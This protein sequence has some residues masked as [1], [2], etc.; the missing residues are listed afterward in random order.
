[1]ILHIL[2]EAVIL[3]WA[4]MLCK[5]HVSKNIAAEIHEKAMPFVLWL[6]NTEEESSESEEEDDE[7]DED[8]YVSSAGQRGG[9]RV[10]Q[11]GVTRAVAGDEDDEEDDVNIDDI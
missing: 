1:M 10:V 5:R 6:K 11:R 2:D 8:N 7:S 4:Q 3:E 9:Q